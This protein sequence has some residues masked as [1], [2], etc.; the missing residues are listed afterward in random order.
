MKKIYI[1][2]CLLTLLASFSDIQ[3]SPDHP[4]TSTYAHMS[5]DE[6]DK[7]FV[8]AV[9]TNQPNTVQGLVQ[10]GADVH[11][12]IT[13]W[14][15][16]RGEGGGDWDV[17][18]SAF[19]YAITHSY[20]EIV[21]I[22]LKK[23]YNINCI[24][25]TQKEKNPFTQL[26]AIIIACIYP[27]KEVCSE[28]HE[29]F[30][31]SVRHSSTDTVK[32]F[33][34]IPRLNINYIDSLGSTALINAAYDGNLKKVEALLDAGAK[35]N[36]TDKFG[37]TALIIAT[38]RGHI[39]IVKLL[40]Q[41]G[42]NVNHAENNGE[43]ALMAAIRNHDVD[44]VQTLLD[45]KQI[46]INHTNNAGNTALMVALNCI[47]TSYI[48]GNKYQYDACVN[49]QK[50]A[51][52]LLQVPGTNPYLKNKNGDTAASLLDKYNNPYKH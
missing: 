18:V 9:E 42:A 14:I 5:Q 4:A 28:I 19:N 23:I 15:H 36:S 16:E 49:S 26:C 7:A 17:T 25:T 1:F 37:N 6:L 27:P 43:T 11:Q 29:A 30:R 50:V 33:L 38:H 13:Y 24:P 2:S 32:V 40:L 47:Q 21:R 22:L 20:T 8:T 10:A 31:W 51:E 39:H 3:S 35:V 48:V 44:T 12:K 41:A 52:T 46:K 45:T 34:S